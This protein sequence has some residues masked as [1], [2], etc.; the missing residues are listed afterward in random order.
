MGEIV[1]TFVMVRQAA[2]VDGAMAYAD[3]TADNPYI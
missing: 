2:Q 3:K 1:P